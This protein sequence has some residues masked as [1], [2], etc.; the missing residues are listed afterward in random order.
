MGNTTSTETTSSDASRPRRLSRI[1][2]FRKKLKIRSNPSKSMLL[3]PKCTKRGVN[4]C[5]SKKQEANLLQNI[6]ENGIHCKD[7]MPEIKHFIENNL[8]H[9]CAR[10]VINKKTLDVHHTAPT[11]HTLKMAHSTQG[12]PKVFLFNTLRSLTCECPHSS[13]SKL[14]Q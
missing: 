12:V 5:L 7:F 6:Q 3:E 8:H 1:Q 14:E 4:R 9:R 10:T 11:R 13:T 2:R